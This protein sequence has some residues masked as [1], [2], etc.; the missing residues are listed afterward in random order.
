MW[1]LQQIMI[2]GTRNVRATNRKELEL[3][4]IIEK[5]IVDVLAVSETK[6]RRRNRKFRTKITYFIFSGVDVKE[7]VKA[8]VSLLMHENLIR[9]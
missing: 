7:R 5:Y 2:F 1:K 3:A 9:Y 8:E 6:R 4:E